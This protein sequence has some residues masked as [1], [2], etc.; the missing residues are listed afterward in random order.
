MNTI[1]MTIAIIMVYFVLEKNKQ[2]Q[3]YEKK[4]KL[5][6]SSFLLSRGAQ[7]H[8]ASNQGQPIFRFRILLLIIIKNY[9]LMNGKLF[10]SKKWLRNV[11]FIEIK[12]LVAM[13]NICQIHG[14]ATQWYK[15]KILWLVLVFFLLSGLMIGHGRN[16]SWKT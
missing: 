3:A 7:S 4:D 15:D 11:C 14:S 16:V 9:L 13:D 2:R 5:I 6:E 8:E 10:V 1:N 12:C